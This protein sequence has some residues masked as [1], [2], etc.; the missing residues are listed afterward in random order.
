[1]CQSAAA[2]ALIP[3]L[4]A[5]DGRA[6]TGHADAV[7]SQAVQRPADTLLDPQRYFRLTD[8]AGAIRKAGHPCEVVKSYKKIAQSVKGGSVYKVDCLEYS[9]RLT[10]LNGQSQ[11]ERFIV[12][13]K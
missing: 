7:P 2:F 11:L 6:P 13:D 3:I 5:C 4:A 1:M 9:F 10:M 12:D 8:L